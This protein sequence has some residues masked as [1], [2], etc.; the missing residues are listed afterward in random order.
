MEQQTLQRSA[1]AASKPRN[2][3]LNWPLIPEG[4]GGFSQVWNPICLSS[5]VEAGQVKGYDFLDGKI[6]VF[7]GE[8]GVAQVLSAFCPHMGANLAK[9]D[10]KGNELRCAFHHWK[11]DRGGACTEIRVG[12]PVPKSAKVFRFPTKEKYGLIWA[13]NGD[14]PLYD[15][16]SFSEN[17]DDL[18]FKTEFHS[19]IPHDPAIGVAGAFDMQHFWAVHEF[20]VDLAKHDKDFTFH[21]HHA[22]Q[23][24]TATIIA[25]GSPVRWEV[26]VFGTNLI[27]ME[28]TN[29]GLWHGHISASCQRRPGETEM[30]MITCVKKEVGREALEMIAGHHN[31]EAQKDVDLLETSRF[32]WGTVTRTDK[33]LGKWLRYVRD[34]PRAHPSDGFI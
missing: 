31:H 4:E 11:F 22:H 5:D 28:G 12:D 14:E 13:F 19:H 27:F 6:V 29:D 24:I 30:F 33:A 2:E 8:D 34:Y 15:L 10:V 7:R 9:G 20:E 25:D 32:N 3:K 17:E 23:K 16:P 1:A 26:D 18:L 21:D